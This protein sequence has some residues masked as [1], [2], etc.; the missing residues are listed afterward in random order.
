ML[1]VRWS[2]FA[3]ASVMLMDPVGSVDQHPPKTHQF[4]G[5]D[6]RKGLQLQYDAGFLG[7]FRRQAPHFV[8]SINF[9]VVSRCHG[10]L[11]SADDPAWVAKEREVFCGM[12][13]FARQ[14]IQLG[15]DSGSGAGGGW[16]SGG[17]PSPCTHWPNS[18]PRSRSWPGCGAC[19]RR[20]RAARRCGRPAVAAAPPSA[21]AAGNRPSAGRRSH[22]RPCG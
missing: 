11:F 3:T 22:H 2:S 4:L 7:R 13:Q 19:P 20:S 12:V 15:L 21:A 6:L 18:T 5:P 10:L 16:A 17:W 8:G 9:L 1:I 14:E